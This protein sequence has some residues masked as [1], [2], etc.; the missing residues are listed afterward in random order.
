LPRL[1]D[2][3][4]YALPFDLAFVAAIIALIFIDADT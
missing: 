1:R 4:S 2:G 3:I